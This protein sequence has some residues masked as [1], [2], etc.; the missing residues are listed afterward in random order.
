MAYNVG[1]IIENTSLK[2]WSIPQKNQGKYWRTCGSGILKAKSYKK[3]INVYVSKNSK[4]K[5][6]DNI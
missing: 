4:K 2:S 6:R 3:I 1:N 5:N